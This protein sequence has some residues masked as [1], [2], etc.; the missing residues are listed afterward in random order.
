MRDAGEHLGALADLAPDPVAH[1]IE[2]DRGLTHFERALDLAE[3]H[4]AALAEALRG[5]GQAPQRLDLVAQEQGRDRQQ[6]QGRADHP[7]DEDRCRVGGEP[8]PRNISREHALRQFDQNAGVARIADRID[9]VRPADPLAQGIAQ[10]FLEQAA[11]LGHLRRQGGA[12]FQDEIDIGQARGILEQPVDFIASMTRPI[13]PATSC[14]RR[15]DTVSQW[16]A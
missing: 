2:G 1:L 14:D 6:H 9:A 4:R 7:Q 5:G 15:F 10:L 3:R 16:R 12:A 13:S 8:L 11:A